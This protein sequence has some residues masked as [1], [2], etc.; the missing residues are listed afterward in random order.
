MRRLIGSFAATT[1]LLITAMPVGAAAVPTPGETGCAAGFEQLSVET[2]TGLGY[3]V[4]ALE[5]A[6]GNNDGWV[7]GHA[8]VEAAA[9]QA[10]PG[11]TLTIYLFGDN[12]LT[13]EH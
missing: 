8:L 10:S 13:P 6:A 12:R 3:R 7:C 11:H 9:D 4:P 5:D 2:L 1:L